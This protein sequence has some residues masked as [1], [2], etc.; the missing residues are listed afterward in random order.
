MLNWVKRSWYFKIRLGRLVVW[1]F[2]FWWRW[3]DQFNQFY[4]VVGTTWGPFTWLVKSQS[5]KRGKTL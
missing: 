4:T 5:K 2:P 3:R 1:V